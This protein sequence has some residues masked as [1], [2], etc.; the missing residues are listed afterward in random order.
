MVWLRIIVLFFYSIILICLG[1]LL[2][3][4]C[5]KQES[6]E[7]DENNSNINKLYKFLDKRS[8]IYKL[9]FG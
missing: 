3:S 7:V 8:K 5:N 6:E 9:S 1:G 4:Q 2:L